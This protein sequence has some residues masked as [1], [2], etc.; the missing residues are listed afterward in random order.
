MISW[1]VMTLAVALAAVIGKTGLGVL[2]AYYILRVR[3]GEY[4]PC[5][6]SLVDHGSL[7]FWS[8]ACL[9]TRG[10]VWLTLLRIQCFDTCFLHPRS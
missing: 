2:R 7:R 9:R 6:A 1:G 8:L 4:Q 10:F 5:F 3:A